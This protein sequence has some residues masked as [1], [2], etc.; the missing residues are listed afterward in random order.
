MENVYPNASEVSGAWEKKKTLIS[1]PVCP[2]E[3]LLSQD[4]LSS[5]SWERPNTLALKA[6][7]NVSLVHPRPG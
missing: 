2:I 7:H 4:I 5:D 3:E 6:K 1:A